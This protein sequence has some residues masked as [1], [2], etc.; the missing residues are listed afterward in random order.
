MSLELSQ[1]EPAGR[2]SAA[3]IRSPGDRTLAGLCCLVGLGVSF[4]LAACSDG[5]HQDDDLTHWLFAKWAWRS[6][7]YLVNEWG[8]PGFTLLQVLP[9]QAGWLASRCLS[10][11]L[12]ALA[13]WAAF[14]CARH[15]GLPMAWLAAPLTF[16]Q[17]FFL[18]LSYTTLTETVCAFYLIVSL[19]LLY[20]RR[21]VLAAV[22]FSLVLVTRHESVVLLPLWIIALYRAGARWPAYPALL[23]APM[24]HNVVTVVW[25][26]R[27][28]IRVF[29][30]TAPTV[31]YAA[32]TPLTFLVNS[33]ACSSP[34][35]IAAAVVGMPG[36]FRRPSG[37]IV[38]SAVAVFA[39]AQTVLHTSSAY[40]TAG[41]IRFLVCVVPLL[42]V[43]AVAGLGAMVSSDSTRP[44]AMLCFGAVV[45]ALWLSF[46]LENHL[47]DI[48]W[49]RL[50]IWAMRVL[51]P[52]AAG[53]CIWLAV[54]NRPGSRPRRV[55]LWLVPG[56]GAATLIAQLSV[57]VEP[58]R[59]G[60]RQLAAEEAACWLKRAGC[61]RA[62]VLAATPWIDYFWPAHR[63]PDSP[64]LCDQLPEA[65]PGAIL[66]WDERHCARAGMRVSP[67]ELAAS[68]RYRPLWSATPTPRNEPPI[69]VF[70]KL[71]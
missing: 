23:W 24:L 22:V 55:R 42:S 25:L 1:T 50:E 63:P 2:A 14:R 68:G 33:L 41:Y 29:L 6:P 43:C 65:P 30:D 47:R 9:A 7:A 26:G 57:Q 19:W 12:S 27:L 18:T 52:I 60:H 34:A 54:S 69:R 64:W 56:I 46:E 71:R 59:L 31:P 67:N 8:R 51:V 16:A 21:L 49:H 20:E 3:L 58:L 17:P 48:W 44:R 11:V 15:L 61:H 28:P 32:G 39:G 38:P 53:L 66:V 36:V 13:A 10:G 45:T 37:W 35:I 5:I 70:E 40:G 62:M 4:L